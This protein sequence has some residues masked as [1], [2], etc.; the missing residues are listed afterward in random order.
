MLKKE[1]A[2]L[3]V[4]VSTLAFAQES[5]CQWPMSIAIDVGTADPATRTYA[6]A[7]PID[8]LVKITETTVVNQASLQAS[9]PSK[10]TSSPAWS[11]LQSKQSC[12]LRYGVAS[13][14]LDPRPPNAV[15]VMKLGVEQWWCHSATVPCPSPAY[16]GRWCRKDT[17][18]KSLGVD[19]DSEIPIGLVTGELPPPMNRPSD[20]ITE[21]IEP[22]QGKVKTTISQSVF[23]QAFIDSLGAPLGVIGPVMVQ[24]TQNIGIQ[25]LENKTNAG[26]NGV[27]NQPPT[28]VNGPAWPLYYPHLTA[29]QFVDLGSGVL[30]IQFTK[31]ATPMREGSACFMAQALQAQ[32]TQESAGT[33][34][35]KQIIQKATQAARDA[36][37]A[38]FTAIKKHCPF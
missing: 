11:A 25:Y 7:P 37:C 33:D 17:S 21:V 13:F 15:G 10:V 16:P 27:V 6:F 30:G 29:A 38:P 34:I 35:G 14:E 3:S 9:F 26:L 28:I 19:S 23:Q 36:S 32:L 22:I 12:N 2:C 31:V 4:L 5:T 8:G 20:P 1:L 24:A 18:G